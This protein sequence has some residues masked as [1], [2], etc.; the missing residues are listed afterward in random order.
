MED[1]TTL[2]KI[3]LNYTGRPQKNASLSL[4][5]LRF[6][7]LNKFNFSSLHLDNITTVLN[8]GVAWVIDTRVDYH[9]VA[10]RVKVKVKR[11][12]SS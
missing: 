7:N 10:S 12:S 4:L 9:F 8:R 2:T 11:Y 5:F 6:I 3:G 1:G